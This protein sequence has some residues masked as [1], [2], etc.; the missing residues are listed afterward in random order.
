M[1]YI[2]PLALAGVAEANFL[3]QFH[4][5]F[6]I[7]CKLQPLVTSSFLTSCACPLCSFIMHAPYAEENGYTLFNCF[8]L[9]HREAIS[10]SVENKLL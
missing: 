4:L 2:F 6:S 5:E 8:S 3:F 9:I 1:F 7:N 10:F